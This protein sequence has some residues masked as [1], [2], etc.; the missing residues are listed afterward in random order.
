MNIAIFIND[1]SKTGGTEI[2][3]ISYADR[4]KREGNDVFF[5]SM[6]YS[7]KN[8]DV[9]NKK[10]CIL[11]DGSPNSSLYDKEINNH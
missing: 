11:R 2:V 6:N 8:S 4:L 7:S 10:Y 1:I 5:I 9:S 3:S